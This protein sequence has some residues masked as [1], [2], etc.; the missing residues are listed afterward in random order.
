MPCIC[1]HSLCAF[2]LSSTEVYQWIT[3]VAT[4]FVGHGMV[5]V[6][7]F[8]LPDSD[9][10]IA[11]MMDEAANK[12]LAYGSEETLDTGAASQKWPQKHMDLA[13]SQGHAWWEPSPFTPEMSKKFVGINHLTDREIDLLNL[14]KVKLPE[15]ICRLIEVSQSAGRSR[16][17]AEDKELLCI[18]SRTRLWITSACRLAHGKELLRL[19]GVVYVS[20][21]VNE[22]SHDFLVDL[23][24][25]AFDTGCFTSALLSLLVALARGYARIREQSSE[26]DSGVDK[27]LGS[28]GGSSD[29]VDVLGSMW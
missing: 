23:A 15:T 5:A 26:H 14:A 18:H 11:K 3:E 22:F 1:K 27:P 13:S 17:S 28:S 12:A 25:N 9:Q 10:A 19:Q 16:P 7:K 8:F 21:A 4:L 24:G 20:P 2:N 6:D 29:D